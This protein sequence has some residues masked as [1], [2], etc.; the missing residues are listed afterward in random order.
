MF[1][2]GKESVFV[3]QPGA[4]SDFSKIPSSFVISQFADTRFSSMS[5]PTQAVPHFS[6]FTREQCEA[7]HFAGLEICGAPACR[8]ITHRRWRC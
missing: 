3:S 2:R 7:V 6:L 4:R 8:W 5:F 1:I